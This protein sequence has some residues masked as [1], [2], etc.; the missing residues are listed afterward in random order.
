MRVQNLHSVFM[1]GQPLGVECACGRRQLLSHKQLGG[2]DGNMKELRR[3]KEQLKCLGCGQRPKE[4]RVRR[5]VVAPNTGRLAIN[6]VAHFRWRQAVATT[7][8]AGLSGVCSPMVSNLCKSVYTCRAHGRS[9]C[10]YEEVGHTNPRNVGHKRPFR[11]LMVCR[12]GVTFVGNAVL[13]V[14]HQS[15]VTERAMDLVKHLAFG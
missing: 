3:L 5:P 12:P 14:G 15:V 1:S 2:C 7:E 4:L 10:P 9:I 8:G 11:S 6:C 13:A